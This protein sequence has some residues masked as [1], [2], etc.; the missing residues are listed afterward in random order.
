MTF[1]DLRALLLMRCQQPILFGGQLV[2]IHDVEIAPS[3]HVDDAEQLWYFASYAEE[4][5]RAVA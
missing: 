1:E 5:R 4:V 2:Q 3:E